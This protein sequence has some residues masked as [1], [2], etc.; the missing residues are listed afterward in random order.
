MLILG[1][2]CFL[3]FF[4]GLG[5]GAIGD[6]DE[7]FYAEASREMVISGDWLTP[8][9]NYELRFQKPI[10]FYWL[11]SMAY[12]AAGVGEA[13]ARFPAALAGFG[14]A[15]LT[16]L[17]GRR[18][19][20]AG[21]GF[22]AATV[23][24]TSFGYF[25]IGRLSL[26]DLPLAFFI[27]AATWGLIEGIG[28]PIATATTTVTRRRLWLSFAGVMMGLGLLTKGPVGVALPV[29]AALPVWWKERRSSS[30]EDGARMPGLLDCVLVGGLV[31][32]VAAPWFL[33]MAQHHGLA[34]VHRFF[35]GENLERFATDRYNEPRPLWFY[36]PIVLGGLMPWSPFILL[37]LP[38]WHRV[39][40]RE[41]MVTRAEWRAILWA[42]VP[43]VF[44]SAS[45]GK[46]PR[47]ILPMLPPMALLLARTVIARLPDALPA[48]TTRTGRQTALAW[49]GTLSAV[50]FMILGLLLHR[51]RPLLFALT[52]SLALVCTGI[53][54]VAAL[55]VLVAS[56]SRRRW[57]LPVT[58][59]VA[60]IA[61][62]LSL[63][64]SVASAADLEPVQV[65][66]RKFAAAYQGHEPS[67]T[68]RVFVR[69]LVFY[70]GVKQT[71]LVQP[72][73]VVEFLRQPQRVLC[74]ITKDDLSRLQREHD[75]T[76]RTLAEV[77]YFNPA[78][79]RLR[80]LLWPDPSRD[81]ETVLLVT[82]Q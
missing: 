2:V 17:A 42:A 65:M 34:Y 9:Y 66:A 68:Y 78:G 51:A 25:S 62:L 46:Q 28:A 16:Y 3:T 35:I 50:L 75:L 71:D 7:A 74:V 48:T 45:I 32:L 57:A 77:Q 22:F 23:V 49:C 14:L 30:G 11:V 21:T 58:M 52:P 4:A 64:Y 59:A 61:T 47:Y 26:P 18:W 36:L 67:A 69:N 29:L 54:T 70:T 79:V 60:S 19:F 41:R 82:N 1:L 15:I 6:S 55:S 37:W 24:A 33:A 81:L 53:I 31:L 43:F 8:Y 80:T 39:F 76:P 27:A 38:T 20:D 13:A 44:Y 56:W 5:R 63:Q 40:K 12:K 73:E 72:H 10:L